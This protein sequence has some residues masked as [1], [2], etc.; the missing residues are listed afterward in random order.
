MVAS[1]SR[2]TP[3]ESSEARRELEGHGRIAGLVGVIRMRNLR[4]R[5]MI[6]GGEKRAWKWILGGKVVRE[7]LLCPEWEDDRKKMRDGNSVKTL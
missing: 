4:R 2:S 5:R 3:S 7:T 6:S 1:G